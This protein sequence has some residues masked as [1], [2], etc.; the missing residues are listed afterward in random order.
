M[1]HKDTVTEPSVSQSRQTHPWMMAQA[2]T[3]RHR[4]KV[5]HGHTGEGTSFSLEKVGETS[6]SRGHLRQDLDD[7]CIDFL[8]LL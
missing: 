6:R 1:R 4:G 8:W 2:G 7:E 3:R 5:C